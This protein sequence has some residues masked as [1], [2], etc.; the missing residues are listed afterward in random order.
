MYYHYTKLQHAISII[1]NLEV[2]LSLADTINDPFDIKNDIIY[3]DESDPDRKELRAC[4]ENYFKKKYG[5]KSFN[6]E[7]IIEN[8]D[9]YL[10]NFNERI[11]DGL[12]EYGFFCTLRSCENLQM[13]SY[14]AE[15]HAGV[16]IEF[17]QSNHLFRNGNKIIYPEKQ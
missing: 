3:D 4:L 15:K 12:N 5:N 13:W 11:R 6:I 14:Y 2:K 7:I 17:N 8:F 1:Q 10:S 16:V 9:G